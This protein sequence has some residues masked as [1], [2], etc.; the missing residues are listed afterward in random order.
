MKSAP[1]EPSVI[2]EENNEG[3]GSSRA[4]LNNE[5]KRG[6]YIAF[7]VGILISVVL[8][9]YLFYDLDFDKFTAE[10]ARFN[11]WVALP[12]EVLFLVTIIL[13]ALR[14]QLLFPAEQQQKLT[15]RSVIES[16]LIGFSATSILPMRAGEIIRPLYLQRKT[17]V[18]LVSGIAS[19]FTERIFDLVSLLT[20]ATVLFSRIP[21]APP[22][23][24]TTSKWLALISLC[25]LSGII[26]CAFFG[27]FA[28]RLARRI[29]TPLLPEKFS[30]VIFGLLSQLI[31]TLGAVKGVKNLLLILAYSFGIWLIS[32]VYYQIST[33]M[34]GVEISFLS[35]L[36]LT[37]TI[38]FAVAA[39]SSPGFIGTY[40]FGC[41]LTLTSMLGHSNEFSLA[42]GLAVHAVQTATLLLV[43]VLVVGLSGM[44]LKQLKDL[45]PGLAGSS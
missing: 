15:L 3:T 28:E 14:A 37:V 11:P 45:D 1:Q 23:L 16:V 2:G 26:V 5:K 8:L 6:S 41:A 9:G 38:A 39:P 34:L 43:T 19:M 18:P 20:L 36:L 21:S 40:Q 25:G 24:V 7:T 13:R 12:M 32:G 27:S 22:F 17:G 29:L 35:G 42:Y 31:G 44:K 33:M 10:F 30:V 4:R